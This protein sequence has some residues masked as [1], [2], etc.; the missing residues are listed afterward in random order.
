MPTPSPRRSATRRHLNFN[1]VQL[2]PNRQL[3]ANLIDEAIR[4]V[5]LNLNS[6]TP[7]TQALA[8]GFIRSVI[9]AKHGS[10]N[11][12]REASGNLARV[13]RIGGGNL[14]PH[15]LAA[16][17]R[18]ATVIQARARGMTGRRRANA[19]R[20]V[21]VFGPNGIPMIATPMRRR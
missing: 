20:A 1:N 2:S 8:H 7:A 18:A 17:H 6:F 11:A 12:L 21:V 9:N 4:L 3:L 10:K 16:A 15:R 5:H 14:S 19:R 13:R